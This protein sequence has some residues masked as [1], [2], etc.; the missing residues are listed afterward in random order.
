[1]DAVSNKIAFDPVSPENAG[2][3]ANSGAVTW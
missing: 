3:R 2:E 1:M